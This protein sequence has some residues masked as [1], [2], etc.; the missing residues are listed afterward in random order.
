M[1]FSPDLLDNSYYKDVLLH[2]V[3]FTS[4]QTLTSSPETLSLVQEY[5][6]NATDWLVDFADAMVKMSKIEVLTGTDGEIRS[7]CRV[8]NS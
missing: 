2:K 5:A 1:N 4:D 3:V 7:N 6:S 8:I